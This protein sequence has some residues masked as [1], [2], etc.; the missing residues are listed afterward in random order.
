MN[1]AI[2]FLM[3][4]VLGFGLFVPAESKATISDKAQA[5]F[6]I[7]SGIAA[8]LC[9]YIAST[10]KEQKMY[11]GDSVLQKAA[12]WFRRVVWGTAAKK[13]Q[14]IEKTESGEFIIK[15]TYTKATGLFGH[16]IS[17]YDA[18]EKDIKRAVGFGGIVALCSIADIKDI[19]AGL[20]KNAP[21][22]ELVKVPKA[23]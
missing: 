4:T 15:D 9:I 5:A 13:V 1:Y 6:W 14:K 16:I 11:E 19:V 7:T 20:I 17:F 2:K 12:N 21:Y 22:S 23:A 10:Q 8:G 18:N 3:I